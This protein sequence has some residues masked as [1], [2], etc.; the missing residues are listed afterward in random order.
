MT[1]SENEPEPGIGEL[2]QP[3]EEEEQEE[4]DDITATIEA[5]LA[6]LETAN[7]EAGELIQFSGEGEYEV[8]NNL[9]DSSNL[10]AG[11]GLTVTHSSDPTWVEIS[12]DSPSQ[13]FE[14]LLEKLKMNSVCC[15]E[16]TTMIV[17]QQTSQK[18]I[19]V[20]FNCSECHTSVEYSIPQSKIGK[21]E[22]HQEIMEFIDTNR[23]NQHATLS[24]IPHT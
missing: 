20:R 7:E 15:G 4:P 19:D 23:D 10:V 3:K 24:N 14:G 18:V 11:Q 8:D 6:D 22:D 17:E 13:V 2:Y 12:V 21:S 5:D 16:D 1:E 9:S